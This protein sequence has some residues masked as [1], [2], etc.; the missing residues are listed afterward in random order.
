VKPEAGGGPP[1]TATLFQQ[2]SSDGG[3]GERDVAVN[4]LGRFRLAACLGQ[5]LLLLFMLSAT[6]NAEI[7]FRSRG[8]NG[9]L[10]VLV[11]GLWGDPLD[12]F[13]PWPLTMVNDRFAHNGEAL[14]EFTVMALGYPARRGDR[15]TP[16]EAAQNLLGELIH[17]VRERSYKEIYFI[18]HSLGGIITKQILVEASVRH[19]TLVERTRAVFLIAVPSTNARFGSMLSR[20][21]LGKAVAGPII[22]YLVTPQGSRYLRDLDEKW[23]DLLSGR[24]PGIRI[25]QHCAYETRPVRFGP[26][27]TIVV[28]QSESE[29]VC[30]STLIANKESHVSIAK[31]W[32][33]SPVHVWVRTHILSASGPSPSAPWAPFVRPDCKPLPPGS[34]FRVAG[35]G[36]RRKLSFLAEVER[37]NCEPDIVA[38]V[39]ERDRR[40]YLGHSSDACTGHVHYNSLSAGTK[41]NMPRSCI[42]DPRR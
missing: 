26:F 24:V 16:A 22:Q 18:A 25:S 29:S 13:G 39:V 21:S 17:E 28:S 38:T 14:S 6:A 8:S 42:N 9:K 36:A 10:I 23:N 12:S 15:L 19:R 5:V 31:A 33:E 34:R 20:L 7:E 37:D 35:F 2:H 41:I 11:H 1:F 4:I 40:V 32:G 27:A 30:T 3:A